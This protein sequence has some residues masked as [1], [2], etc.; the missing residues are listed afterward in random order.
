[1]NKC[2]NCF[3]DL[4][5]NWIPLV[6]SV[7]EDEWKVENFLLKICSNCVGKALQEFKEKILWKF[8]G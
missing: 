6:F 8:G 5:E 4:P 3:A 2:V 7:T 1:M